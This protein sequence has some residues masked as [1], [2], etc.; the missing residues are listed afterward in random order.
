[1]LKLERINK[2]WPPLGGIVALLITIFVI[3][4]WSIG[5]PI[6]E[7]TLLYLLNLAVLM[8]HEFEEYVFPGGFQKFANTKSLLALPE[9]KHSEPISETVIAV[10]NL[11]AWGLSILAVLFATIA[12][13]LGFGMIIFNVVNIL[14]HLI[15]FQKK[16]KGYNPGVVTAVL[17]IP[18]LI[19]SFVVIINQNLLSTGEYMIG[20]IIGFLLGISLPITGAIIRK[21]QITTKE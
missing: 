5:S 20:V 19:F 2:I 6:S 9:P 1:M 8:F 7:L 17:M 18:F 3:V 14:G 12:P 10:I 15:I 21:R 11:G 16:A 4:S 13:W